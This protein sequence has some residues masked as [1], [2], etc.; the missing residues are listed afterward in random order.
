MS[1][2]SAGDRRRVAMVEGRGA[3]QRKANRLVVQT[4]TGCNSVQ[5]RAGSEK[6]QDGRVWFIG[7]AGQTKEL[8]PDWATVP[9]QRAA[10]GG[11]GKPGVGRDPAAALRVT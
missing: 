3:G 7:R 4:A 6:R 1:A 11:S 8:A 10:G 5:A 2:I 9:A